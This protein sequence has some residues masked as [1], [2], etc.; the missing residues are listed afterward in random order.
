MGRRVGVENEDAFNIENDS[1][2][3]VPLQRFE[4]WRPVRYG[5]FELG[6]I[7]IF[8]LPPAVFGSG[9][10]ELV[11]TVAFLLFTSQFFSASR[12]AGIPQLEP[13]VSGGSPPRS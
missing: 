4:V 10:E 1:L 9:A 6:G 8:G 5:Q 3:F 13:P 12:A 2:R 7:G 11:Q